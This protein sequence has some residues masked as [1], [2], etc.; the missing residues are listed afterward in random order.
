MLQHV[1]INNYDLKSKMD[2]EFK[3]NYVLV[4]CSLIKV[5]QIV[6]CVL[7]MLKFKNPRASRVC[8]IYGV[9]SSNL[10]TVK[11]CFKQYPIT[12]ITYTFLVSFMIFSYAYRVSERN[13]TD[14]GKEF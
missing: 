8:K 13:S 1:Y 12:F 5:C 4:I 10:F 14:N 11:C 7:N 3:L 6:A 2:I 9:S